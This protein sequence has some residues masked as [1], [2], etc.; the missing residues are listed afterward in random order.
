MV[1]QCRLPQY[2]S[3]STA[4]AV[5]CQADRR[6]VRPFASLSRCQPGG[7]GGV[8]DSFRPVPLLGASLE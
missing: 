6:G 8:T 1:N 5:R 3:V 4:K 2:G 7:L